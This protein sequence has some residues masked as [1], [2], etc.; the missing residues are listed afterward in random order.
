MFLLRTQPKPYI[1]RF[2]CLT[3]LIL[4]TVQPYSNSSPPYNEHS[5]SSGPSGSTQAPAGAYVSRIDFYGGGSTSGAF[6]A[7][8]VSYGSPATASSTVPY[9]L[10]SS[11]VLES[12]FD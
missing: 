1:F 11:C 3:T 2:L 10:S 5:G 9:T 8:K 12:S 7:I 4:Q 6:F